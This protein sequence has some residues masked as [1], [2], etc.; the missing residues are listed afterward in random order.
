MN[1]L[2]EDM[3]ACEQT[4]GQ[5]VLEHG[6]SVYNTFVNIMFNNGVFR[7]PQWFTDNRSFI[8]NN[9]H[10]T[11]TIYNYLVYHDCGKPYCRTIENG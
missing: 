3:K 1:T 8:N 2:I 7:L 4:A 11:N 5:S 10:D 6:L 9:I